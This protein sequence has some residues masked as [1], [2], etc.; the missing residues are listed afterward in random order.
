MDHNDTKMNGEEQSVTDGVKAAGADM[1]AT[2]GRV[3]DDMGAN[4]TGEAMVADAQKETREHG[5]RGDN[6]EEMAQHAEH[7]HEENSGMVQGE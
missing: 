2:A 5:D 4:E 1:Q 7:K 6:A 3:M